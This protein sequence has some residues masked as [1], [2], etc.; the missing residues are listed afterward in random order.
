MRLVLA[1]H[2]TRDPAGAQTVES[3]ARAVRHR[4]PEVPVVVGYADVR[5]PTVAEVTE[6]RSIVVPAFLG[7]GYHVRVDVPAQVGGRGRVT[8]ALGPD[9]DLVGVVRD[10]LV[11]AGW[12]G[13]PVVLA[14]AGSREVGVRAEVE[15]VA[16]L[17]GEMLGVRVRVGYVMGRPTVGEMV[18]KGWAVGSWLLAPGVFHRMVSEYGPVVG[19]PLGDHPAVVDLIVRRFLSV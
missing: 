15:K 11:E 2:G 6:E 18:E 19:A 4:L 14:A 12:T 10:R 3:L 17:L 13:E 16:G 5:R 9:P 7:N 8:S 1:A